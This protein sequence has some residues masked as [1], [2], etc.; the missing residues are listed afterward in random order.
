M[1]DGTAKTNMTRVAPL[2]IIG[3]GTLWGLIGL[4]I[5]NFD[6]KFE[7]S[8]MGIVLIR[9]SFTI[10]L[11]FF[12]LLIKD[13]SLFRIKLKDL[14][15]FIG[16]GC[17]S[18]VFFNYCY[19][20]A[21]L[22]TSMS[23]AAVLLY[24]APVFVVI[25]S[26]ILFK[27]ALTARKIIGMIGA[28][29]GCSLVTGVFENAGPVNT[30]GLLCGLGA[31]VGYALYSIFSRYALLRGYDP[32]TINFYTFVLALVGV[33]PFVNPADVVSQV[34]AAPSYIPFFFFFALVSTVLPF[35]LYTVGLSH[36]TS[37]N[38][39]ILATIEP[40]V[41][42]LVGAVFMHEALSVLN[43]IGVA[44][45]VLAVIMLQLPAR[46]RGSGANG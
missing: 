42:T 12:I 2:L 18:I 43:G 11:L 21:I 4:F 17:A 31:G 9:A 5:H 34:A 15:C 23:M 3:A 36:T 16:T 19:F 8:S 29:L 6:D 25:L 41:A 24:T 38:A 26:R 32:L 45:V 14:W 27:E 39:S 22:E 10:V 28:L 13:R 46:S 30:T 33:L 7:F 37:G 40:V 44:V 1:G 20:R 35:L